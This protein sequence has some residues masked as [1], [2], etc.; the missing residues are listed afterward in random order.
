M[1]PMQSIFLCPISS[2]K[3]H[4]NGSCVL[5]CTANFCVLYPRL[6][7]IFLCSM[8][9]LPIILL[10]SMSLAAKYILASCV[11]G[12]TVY[13]CVIYY[14]LHSIFMFPMSLAA[15]YI[16][17]S[18]VLGYTVYSC[19]LCPRLHSIFMCPMHSMLLCLTNC[20][21]IVPLP[22]SLCSPGLQ[23]THDT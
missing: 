6:H 20:C 5:G 23:D 18:Y 7:S 14:R 16:P 3:N 12:C 10:C 11:L 17:V 22:L 1:C 8:S 13:S 9:R 4:T 19:V 15:Q 2:G 21:Y